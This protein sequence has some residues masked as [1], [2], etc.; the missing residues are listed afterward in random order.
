M[1]SRTGIL[2]S[3]L[4]RRLT[5]ES[6]L[7]ENC[8]FKD[9]LSPA[10]Y[11]LRVGSYSEM[12]QRKDLLPGEF[13]EIPSCSFVLLGTIEQVRLPLD[14][15][16]MMYLRSTYARLGLMP[17]FQGLVDPGY[18]GFLTVVLHNP[19]PEPI[20]VSHGQRIC[21]LVFEKLLEPAERGYSGS[22]MRSSGAQPAA[23][24]RRMV[25]TIRGLPRTLAT[26]AVKGCWK[27]A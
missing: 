8:K 10:S 3:Q 7:I 22:Y 23:N 11:E 17:W 12:G 16:G 18:K 15:L 27:I 24:D 14:I 1:T 21:H 25:R 5:R 19:M 2:P 26:R 20:I 13:L 4:I 9:C 6:K